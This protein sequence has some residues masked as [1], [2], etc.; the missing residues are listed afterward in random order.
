MSMTFNG[1]ELR[2]ARLFNGL[3]LEEVADSVGKTRQYIHKLETGQSAPTEQLLESLAFIL[4]VQPAFFENIAPSVIVEEQFHFR[5]QFTTKVAVKD[6]A[7]AKCKLIDRLVVYLDQELRFPTVRITPELTGLHTV[8]KIEQAAERCRQEWGLAQGPISNMT[9]LAESIVGAIVTS[10]HSDSK[11]IDALSLAT[12]RPI[13]R[14]NDAKGSVCR[15]RFDV[16]HELGHFVLHE[17]I[18]TGDRITES[19]ANRFASALL[20]PRSM[21]VKLFPKPRGT[22][23]D[24]KGLSEFKLHWKVSKAAIFYRARQLNLIDENQYKSGV[25]TLKRTG[26][27]TG[28]KEDY[29]I[30]LEPPEL[31][32]N[33]LAILADKKGIYAEDIA[34]TLHL[35]LSLLQDIVG[36]NFPER[37][38]ETQHPNLRLVK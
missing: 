7:I 15:Q 18:A 4:K 19:E 28:E 14:L 5:K 11:E 24:W 6:I 37:K 23:L 22:R 16:G 32:A 21:M 36:L 9:R 29:L 30:P 1:A 35:S 20:I 25:I 26:E 31:L 27:A 33:S 10:F 3:S 13:I 34:S 2:L 38:V 17:G 12:K 8:E